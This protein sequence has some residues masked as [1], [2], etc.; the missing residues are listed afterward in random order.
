M[1]KII[2][3][4]LAII[5]LQTAFSQN[6][7]ENS[8]MFQQNRE[9]A[10]ASFYPYSST[11]KAL[12][13]KPLN[14]NFIKCLNGKWKFNFTD[15]SDTGIPDF[16]KIGYDDTKWD[17]IPVPGN[18]EMYGYGY[19]HYTNIIYPFE[20]NPPFIKK[21]QNSVGSY[22][23]YFEVDDNWLNREVYIQLGSVKSG[24]YLWINGNK[25]GYNQDSKLPA[26]FNITPYLKKGRN[27]LAVKVFKFTDGSYL[28]DQDFW[29]LS[30]I[31]RDVYLFARPKTHISD[32]FSKAL[33]DAN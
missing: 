8:E 18:W 19:P 22:I 14:E 5:S 15:H 26:E 33:L 20:K 9:K 32:F 10:R 25:V 27:K 16:E 17:E 6:D 7:W 13:D 4:L 21:T 12:D 23:T 29:R 28:E 11:E 30:G 31:Q 1:K 2:F 24:Y 3:Y